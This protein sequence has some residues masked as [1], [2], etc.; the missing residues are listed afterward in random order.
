VG[1]DQWNSAT[2]AIKIFMRGMG[3]NLT[4]HSLS[5]EDDCHGPYSV[6]WSR[7]SR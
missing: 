6:H 1:S 3:A 4:I 2:F 7:T 5:R